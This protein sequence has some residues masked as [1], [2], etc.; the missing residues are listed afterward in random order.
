LKW[1]SFLKNIGFSAMVQY[2][3]VTEGL[4]A[5]LQLTPAKA[6]V[7]GA[8]DGTAN[9]ISNVLS[10]PVYFTEIMSAS[11]LSQVLQGICEDIHKGNKIVFQ[12]RSGHVLRAAVAILSNALGCSHSD[13]VCLPN[14]VFECS[15]PSSFQAW[16]SEF[17]PFLPK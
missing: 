15:T 7:F 8:K 2:P 9:K 4:E 3:K 11:V 16:V 14:V 12:C 17:Q 10:V 6:L 5:A 1:S 13:L